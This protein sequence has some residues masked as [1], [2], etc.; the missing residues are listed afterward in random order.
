MDR[1]AYV[2][3]TNLCKSCILNLP[4]LN[5][6]IPTSRDKKALTI[7]LEAEDVLDR[8]GMLTNVC[9]RSLG[10]VW[11][12]SLNISIGMSYKKSS[13]SLMYLIL[14]L[15]RYISKITKAACTCL[16]CWFVLPA[17]S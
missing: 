1:L 6:T 17:Y 8:G 15:L 4:K 7:V 3:F 5:H 16:G 13:R 14:N 10:L 9:R 2:T 11:I 12:P